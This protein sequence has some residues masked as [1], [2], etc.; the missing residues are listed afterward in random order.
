[1][2]RRN[3]ETLVKSAMADTPVVLIHGARQTG[4]TTLVRALA[5][6]IGGAT[7]VTLD[8]A[9]MLAAATA[10]SQ[11]FVDRID[12]TAIID[13]IQKAPQLFSA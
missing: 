13:E 7:Y 8:D 3:I 12:G 10:D 11:G 2:I 6:D 1:M 4:K 9:T 5:R